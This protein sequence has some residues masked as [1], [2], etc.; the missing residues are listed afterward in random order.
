[1]TAPQEAFLSDADDVERYPCP[2]YRAER[3][4][5]CRSR[6]GAASPAPTAP[7]AS[8]GCSASRA[9]ARADPRRP[10]PRPAVAPWHSG[11]ARPGTGHPERRNPYRVGPL[12]DA[13]PGTSVAARRPHQARRPARQGVLREDRHPGPSPP[14]V[15]GRDGTPRPRRCRTHRTRRPPLR[16]RPHPERPGH[17]RAQ[18]L[19][20]RL[21]RRRG[22]RGGLHEPR[23]PR[24]R[25]RDRGP[26]APHWL[27]AAAS[28]GRSSGRSRRR[29]SR[30]GADIAPIRPA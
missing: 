22:P 10:R 6:S 25:A 15:R 21:L 8:P 19:V 24:G 23:Y 20:G 30:P 4:S 18:R 5:P 16:P 1:M 3:G 29:S 12:L 28:G 7:A 26:A 17:R 13:H 9:P 14:A 11:T 2:R 27:I